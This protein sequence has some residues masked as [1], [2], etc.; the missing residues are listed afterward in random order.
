MGFPERLKELRKSKHFNQTKLAELAQTNESNI[1][2]YERGIIIPSSTIIV[3]IAKVLETTV[4]YLVNGTVNENIQTVDTETLDL[5]QRIQ[6]LSVEDKKA[7][8]H[9][10]K[11]MESQV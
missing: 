4:D 11:R 7:V 9:I 5:A 2:R 3:N 10:V 6:A 8:L 1:S